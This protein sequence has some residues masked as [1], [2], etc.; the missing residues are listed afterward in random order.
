MDDLQD[1]HDDVLVEDDN[2]IVTESANLVEGD[3]LVGDDVNAPEVGMIYK[4]EK[5]MCD[6][7]KKY[8]YV[9][10]FPVKKRNSKKGDDGVMRYV[11][12]TCSGEGRIPGNSGNLVKPQ[13]IVQMGCK[14]RISTSC[15]ILGNWRINTVHLEHNHET[16]PSKSRLFRCNRYLSSNVKR[17]LQVNDLTG[18]PL[19]KSY[20][21]TVVEAEG[22]ENMTCIEKDCRNYIE[23]VRRL[24][25]GEGDAAAIQSYFSKMQ[26]QCTG[27]FFSIDL[28]DES[29]LRNV[30]WA[31]NRCRQAYR[32]FGDVS[33][34]DYE[35]GWIATIDT[36]GLH[37]NDW[38]SGLYE[39]RERW[40]PCF[41]KTIFWAGMSTTQRSESMN[42]FFDGYVH[43]KTS[44]KPFVEQYERALRNK[45][46]KE[47]QADFKSFSQMVPCATQF[48][49]E[50]QYR[51]VYTIS[52]LREV[53]E[54]FTGKVYC[55]VASTT[56]GSSYTTY[57]V[58]EC[59]I[60]EGG[61]RRKTF[62]VSFQ[63]DKC[64]I[65]CS[66]R[67]FEFR[68]ILCRHAI[69]VLNCNDV[70]YIPDRYILRRWRK[71]VIRAHTRVAVNYAGL[72]STPS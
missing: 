28:D 67:L 69:T 50:E 31:D 21:S 36:Y 2:E 57:N 7:Y 34:E 32:E 10:G 27:F 42:A 61:R 5:D 15:D 8:A 45:V 35:D 47:F 59:I 37:E 11:T 54:E 72:V 16:S 23:Q 51:S 18:I 46:E 65:V 22:Y 19:H 52:K 30:F 12:F 6:F 9:I 44:L 1:Q 20:N 41:L 14:A 43:S 68:G 49:M 24:R 58:R 39:N 55:D 33:R 64:D 53:Q 63:R 38:L 26:A 17:K 62:A 71:D 48:E 40:V 60:Y 66:C 3:T 13:P 4:D 56:E 25:L 70:T 29:R